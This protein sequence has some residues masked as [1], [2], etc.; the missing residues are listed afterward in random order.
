MSLPSI[1]PIFSHPVSASFSGH[2]FAILCCSV[3]VS[4]F[5]S[6]HWICLS[7]SHEEINGISLFGAIDLWTM[8][9]TI[10]SSHISVSCQFHE[11]STCY[12]LHESGW[13]HTWCNGAYVFILWHAKVHAGPAWVFVV[14]WPIIW[15]DCS[16]PEM[17]KHHR[18]DV[19]TLIIYVFQHIKEIQ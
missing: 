8:Q 19:W 11:E 9:C 4:V 1:P 7:R 6:E 15:Y 12:E 5:F 13:V 10:A 3:D 2:E 14:L 16:S 18:V 17:Y